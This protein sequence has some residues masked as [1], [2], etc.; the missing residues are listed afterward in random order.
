MLKGIVKALIG[1]ASQILDN[2]ITTDEERIDAK[3]RLKQV[4][5][6][7]QAQME[8]NITNRWEAD[9]KSD[10]WLS[11]NVRPL[12]LIFVMVCT[13]LLIFIDAGFVSFEVESKWVDLL[14]LVLITIVASYFGGRSLEKIKK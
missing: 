1:D 9:M 14:Q 2:V 11:K 5:L 7:H 3:K 8:Q 12:M 4:I 6:G 13:M 10:S